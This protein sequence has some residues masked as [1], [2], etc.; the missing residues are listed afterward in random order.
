MNP[1]SID[2]QTSMGAVHLTVSDLERSEQFYTEV[3]G[4]KPLPRRDG[5]LTL[6]A[7]GTTPLLELKGDPGAPPRP[8][9]TTGLY[10][11][12]VLMPSRLELARAI[13]RIAEAR[14]PVQGGADHRVSEALYLAD[15]DDNG[16]ELYRDRPRDT[17]TF[18]NG[19]IHME[20]DSLDYEGILAELKDEAA[21][22]DGLAP[23]TRI[24]HMHLNVA[25]LGQAEEFYHGVLGFDVMVRRA[26][27]ALF[28]S[29]GGYHHHL[30]LNVWNGPG[31]PPPP[32]GAIGL[33]YYDIV[34]PD[35]PQ[36][37]QVM[38]RVQ[39]AGIRAEEMDQGF[40]LQDPSQNGLLLTHA[41]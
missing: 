26:H 18:P 35:L 2:P 31:A 19:E 40:L 39:Q 20:T 9:R 28:V 30:G 5:I 21:S 14:Y 11:F 1:Y 6:T 25:D 13:R 15:P 24:G 12:A 23:D 36:L 3:L 27:G 38:G 37:E 33:R 41:G 34:L 32:E 10:H 22:G 4:F 17:W 8:R 16:I 29:A 7:D